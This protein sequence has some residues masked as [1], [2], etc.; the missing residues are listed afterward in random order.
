MVDLIP[1]IKDI[2]ANRR[3]EVLQSANQITEA[4]AKSSS[5]TADGELSEPI[6]KSAF[7]QLE[8]GYDKRFGGFSPAPKFPTPHN[9]LFLLRYWRRENDAR[10]LEMM[11]NTLQ[12]MRQGG[13]YDHIG[14]G[15]HRYSTDPQWL[16]PHF[17]KMLYDQA[18]L[19]MACIE[20][21]QATGKA[22]YKNT[23][24]EIFSYVL[25]DLTSPEGGFYSAEDA[26][27]DGGEGTFY[28]WREN[29]LRTILSPDDADFAI[30]VYNFKTDA[31]H[32]E[33]SSNDS[34]AH[35]I[36]L[37]NPISALAAD[38]MMSE[39]HFTRRLESIRQKLFEYRENKSRPNKD[40][41]I[42][43]DWN[44]L[45]IASLALGAQAFDEQAYSQAARNAVSFI[46]AR[47]RSP[48]GRLLHRFRDGQAGIGATVDD[49]A[50]LIFGLLNLYEATFDLRYLKDAL[51][52]NNDLIEHYWDNAAGGFFFTADDAEKLPVR[53]K[54]I[55]DGAVPSGNSVAAL[56][57]L[58][59]GMITGR[60]AYQDM[61]EGIFKLN[62][63]QVRRAPQAFTMLLSSFDFALGPS[64]HVVIVGRMDSD[65]T[66]EMLTALHAG[67]MPNKIVVLKPANQHGFELMPFADFMK[68]L[69][70]IDG[71]ATAYIGR[72]SLSTRSTTE[73]SQMLQLLDFPRPTDNQ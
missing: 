32:G 63:Q 27:S 69:V 43:V 8:Y 29:E 15:F 52:L 6:L 72:D 59:L 54:E 22:L 38:F 62:S 70:S 1:R 65:N 49:Y 17:E 35:I 5:V 37:V 64:Y 42:L 31:N 9:L 16:V 7:E 44:G 41:K 21:F 25:R 50:F 40:D 53:Q 2:W 51:E 26:D 4:L 3:A 23:A 12:K 67:F 60:P 46:M 71:N 57:L 34:N 18:L 58:R 47:M 36:H 10:A 73:I 24:R 14:F 20:A 39:D 68:K 28:L 66:R 45:M 56:N 55:Y 30:K 33:P 13:I 48:D 61:A 11:E 19:A